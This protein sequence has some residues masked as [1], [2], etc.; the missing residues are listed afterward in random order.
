MI[1][2]AVWLIAFFIIA[3]VGFLAVTAASAQQRTFYDSNGRF[4]GESSTYNGGRNT[5]FS[6]SQG[7]FA[8]SATRNSDGTTTYYDSR[9]RYAGSSSRR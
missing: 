1:V 8:G 5:S 7:R 4:A 3:F 6:D 9:G 2:S